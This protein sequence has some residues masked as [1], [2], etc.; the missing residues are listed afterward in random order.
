MVDV[1]SC[2]SH[3][4]EV[5]NLFWEAPL[6]T[7]PMYYLLEYIRST[8]TARG[9]MPTLEEMR[10]AM[11]M[12]SKSGVHRL[13]LGLE[14]RGFLR[15]TPW[16]ARAIELVA[17][18]FPATSDA[19][20][21][22]PITRPTWALPERTS[23]VRLV[24]LAVSGSRLLPFRG[25]VAAGGTPKASDAVPPSTVSVPGSLVGPESHAVYRVRGSDFVSAGLVDGDMVV[26]QVGGLPCEGRPVVV[27]P[28]E[29]RSYLVLAGRSGPSF[30]AVFPRSAVPSRIVP[31]AS[32]SEL[33]PVRAMFRADMAWT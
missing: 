1:D 10:S 9:F 20:T 29:G 24:S 16:R 32:I 26:A 15:R 18:P 8:S 25:V 12:S 19:V 4:A 13:L 30:V 7:R 33:L 17:K 11:R 28:V 6:L 23:T 31:G 2:R 27:V 22:E 14:E 5:R 3:L 21:S